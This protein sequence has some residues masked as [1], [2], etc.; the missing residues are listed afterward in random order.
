MCCTMDWEGKRWA[1]QIPYFLSLLWNFF[2]SYFSSSLSFRLSR[3]DTC[4]QHVVQTLLH[5]K[6]PPALTSDIST[7]VS[8]VPLVLRR[9]SLTI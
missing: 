1:A 9:P 4:I 8:S 5:L 7:Q 2:I 3:I 6:T